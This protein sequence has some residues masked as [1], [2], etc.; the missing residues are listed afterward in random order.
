[1]KKILVIAAIVLMLFVVG[2]FAACNEKGINSDKGADEG[3]SFKDENSEEYGSSGEK[4]QIHT[5]HEWGAWETVF[6]PDCVTNGLKIKSCTECGVTKAEIIPALGHVSE[7]REKDQS[8]HFRICTRCGEK[9]EQEKHVF[10][11]NGACI[12]CGFLCDY[13][14]GLE[15]EKI[16]GKEEYRVTGDGDFSGDI[17]IVPATYQGLPVTEIGDFAL[18]Y[19]QA[20]KIVLPESIRIIGYQAFSHASARK[21]VLPKYL[22]TLGDSAFSSC[23]SLEKIV[24][25]EGLKSIGDRTFYL[26]MSLRKIV[27]PDSVLEIG[28]QAFDHCY[29]LTSITLGKNLESIEYAFLQCNRLFEVYNRSVLPVV[30]DGTKK[31]GGVASKAKN[32]YG[33]GVGSSKLYTTEDGI[34]YYE[35]EDSVILLDYV[36]DQTSLT[37]PGTIDNKPCNLVEHSF[38]HVNG[39][40]S[41]TVSGAIKNIPYSS[42]LGMKSLSELKLEEGIESI[43]GDCFQSAKISV[44]KIPA[45]LISL[46]GGSFG[47]NVEK[48]EVAADN[49][50]FISAGNCLID[51]ANKTLVLG[52]ATSVIPSDGSVEIIGKSAFQNLTELK[53]IE[54]PASVRKIDTSAFFHTGLLRVTLSEGLQNIGVEAFAYCE[55][56]TEIYI[57]STVKEIYASAFINSPIEKAY[58][59]SADAWL[60]KQTYAGEGVA[61]DE[62]RLADPVLAAEYIKETESYT[63]RDP[64]AMWIRTV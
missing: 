57:P 24:L 10:D 48:I 63:N 34:W 43:A 6:S 29:T 36:G 26:C 39:V 2:M 14:L 31:F 21:I 49:P 40:E 27:I 61:A 17:L 33:I 5:A 19:T 16:D 15:Y 59:A 46:S 41:L 35:G 8:V 3:Q 28:Y 51:K 7:D 42:F 60:I 64:R 58:F 4:D 38:H 47:S 52:C 23:Y 45:S 12:D 20:E 55:K 44:L 37:I 1:M 13:T 62:S 18:G 22:E 56:L 25:P 53:E 9:Y 11:A 32:V 54:I 50:V 30:A